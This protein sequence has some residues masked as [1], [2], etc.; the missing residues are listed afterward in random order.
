MIVEGPGLVSGAP[1]RFQAMCVQHPE[2]V[3]QD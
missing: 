3:E 1:L 2:L